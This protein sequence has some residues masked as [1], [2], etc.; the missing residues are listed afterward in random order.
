MA[1]AENVQCM[2]IQGAGKSSEK[3]CNLRVNP[4]RDLVRN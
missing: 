4:S 1:A 3:K 2:H